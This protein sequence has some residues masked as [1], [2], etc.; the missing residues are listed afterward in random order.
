[1]TDEVQLTWTAPPNLDFGVVVAA[2]GKETRVDIVGR[3]RT[4]NVAVERGLKYCFKVQGS[5]GDRVY[6]SESVPFR[7]ATCRE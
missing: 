4:V 3:V 1:M 2:E 5:D 7:G 6:H